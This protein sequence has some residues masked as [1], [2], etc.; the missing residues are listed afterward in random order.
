M[1]SSLHDKEKN[2]FEKLMI[3]KKP[4]QKNPKTQISV[5]KTFKQYQVPKGVSD[6]WGSQTPY[7]R[8]NK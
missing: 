3:S 8:L 4:I 5:G 6:L 7:Q 1:F 2:A